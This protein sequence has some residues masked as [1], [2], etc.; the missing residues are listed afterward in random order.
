[1][2]KKVLIFVGLAVCLL[3]LSSAQAVDPYVIEPAG[4]QDGAVYGSSVELTSPYG[5]FGLF[6]NA[7]I[8][9]VSILTLPAGITPEMIISA[10]LTVP[11][12]DY[13]MQ[14]ANAG[15]PQGYTINLVHI[16]ATSDTTV[17]AADLNV[18]LELGV[19]DVFRAAGAVSYNAQ[20]IMEYD[21]TDE[22]L[23]D[24][25]DGR[26]TF[27]FKTKTSPGSFNPAHTLDYFM[28]P[29][30]ENTQGFPQQGAELT[31]EVNFR[32][33]TT[34]HVIQPT[35]N[36]DGPV[37]GTSDAEENFPY[38]WFGQYNTTDISMV[39]IHTL[40][41]VTSGEVISATL[42]IPQPDILWTTDQTV[43]GFTMNVKHINA[44]S[45]TTITAGDHTSTALGNIGQLR[46]SGAV[47]YNANRILSYDVTNF[48]KND[49]DAS[50]ASFAWRT[51]VAT[52]N[53]NSIG[54]YMYLPTVE[55]TNGAFPLHGGRLTIV[56]VNTEDQ[57]LISHWWGWKLGDPEPGSTPDANDWTWDKAEDY[58]PDPNL[59]D[60]R[61]TVTMDFG[62]QYAAPGAPEDKENL[63]GII[64][65]RDSEDG[66]R[67]YDLWVTPTL[68]IWKLR[69]YEINHASYGQYVG[70]FHI[71][72]CPSGETLA[73]DR[74]FMPA[75]G[76]HPN[77]MVEPG[78]GATE[79]LG[80][81]S[82]HGCGY[83]VPMQNP[84]PV[85]NYQTTGSGT[86]SIPA[87][88]SGLTWNSTTK[89]VDSV[90]N[91]LPWIH[92]PGLFDSQSNAF[93]YDFTP[94]N[95][96]TKTLIQN[97]LAEAEDNVQLHNQIRIM[98][99]GTIMLT[100]TWTDIKAGPWIP[101]STDGHWI[102]PDAISGGK[103]W[104]YNDATSSYVDAF[105]NDQSSA[106]Y[107]TADWV[108]F[109][110]DAVRSNLGVGFHIKAPNRTMSCGRPDTP[111]YAPGILHEDYAIDIPDFGVLFRQMFITIG[112]KE[113]MEAKS[114][115]LEDYVQAETFPRSTVPYSSDADINGDNVVDLADW[116]LL[117]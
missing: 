6:S 52:L 5:F 98:P 38:G 99:D 84:W 87:I 28:F 8:G 61:G 69:R 85:N 17:S 103:V 94:Y 41:A 114:A 53:G 26:K 21:V 50:R 15:Y 73:M 56:T 76:L 29:T 16:D 42:E 91:A 20:R 63:Y 34:E 80:V 4:N 86:G 18:G 102:T 75:V 39:S 35:T 14:N 65:Y 70:G 82:N 48:V 90:S 92:Y 74:V 30:V 106:K 66:L 11:Q 19:I 54:S 96:A 27:A 1:M 110:V 36:Q 57:N 71:P 112:T 97:Q 101:Y 49:L 77:S 95:S 33:L 104:Y 107:I 59:F 47:S 45:D 9:T 88:S 22:V 117:E 55:N 12:P 67:D 109:F 78:Q 72:G 81:R 58:A 64:Q 105:L 43:L 2:K 60:D 116:T 10:T 113:E 115:T 24:V 32:V 3:M 100:H 111:Q 68:A 108:G 89:T 46:A 83:G 51:Q 7:Q 79:N 44:I 13:V 93:I 25:I 40:P 37:Y 62:S 31:I 23:D